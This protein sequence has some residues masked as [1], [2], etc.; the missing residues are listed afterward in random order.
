MSAP[1]TVFIVRHGE[2]EDE[3]AIHRGLPVRHTL[4]PALTATGYEQAH[5]AFESIFAGLRK[6]GRKR[7][8]GVFCSPTRRT[9]GTALMMSSASVQVPGNRKIIE[10]GF[11]DAAAA[12]AQ[13]I[14]IVVL[15]G[16]C[17]CAK[18]IERLGGSENVVRA[19]LLPCAAFPDNDGSFDAPCI[20]HIQEM[21]DQAAEKA[22]KREGRITVQFC[23]IPEPSS[24]AAAVMSVVP[25]TPLLT[26]LEI[27][28]AKP[29]NVLT[30]TQTINPGPDASQDSIPGA[31]ERQ[32]NRAGITISKQCTDLGP[33]TPEHQIIRQGGVGFQETLNRAVSMA[34]EEECD[35][36]IVV[37]HRE[38]IRSLT[39]RCGENRDLLHI[40]Y[41]CIGS[42]TA[43][44]TESGSIYK[45]DFYGVS[46][47]KDFDE[48][49]IPPIT[50]NQEYETT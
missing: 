22:M 36:I 37:S 16:L 3:A 46:G 42:F 11:Q 8:I 4:D 28:G 43:T 19:G 29:P 38:G 20:Q 7:K 27:G 23:K 18:Q 10:W 31:P 13:A 47:Y 15:N 14:P 35:T 9:I 30:P 50:D 44:P 24:S 1:V 33:R 17:T 45:W 25:M 39:D 48:R 21:Q 2:R 5:C 40:S 32:T 41:C 49:S 34:Q 26:V 12:D 6:E